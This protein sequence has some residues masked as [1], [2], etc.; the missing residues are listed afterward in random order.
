MEIHVTFACV[1]IA[2]CTKF[3]E[4]IRI[5]HIV[6]IVILLQLFEDLHYRSLGIE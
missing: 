3:S 4:I 5:R 6:L 1:I 2:V